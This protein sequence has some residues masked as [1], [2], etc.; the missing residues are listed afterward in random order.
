[1]R[2]FVL[3]TGSRLF[4]PPVPGRR[5]MPFNVDQF[6][7]ARAL[8]A[9]LKSLAGRRATVARNTV[10]VAGGGFTGIETVAEMP[11]RLRAILGDDANIRSSAEQASHIWPRSPGRTPGQ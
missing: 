7:H 1:M 10:V 2:K 5:T 8:D 4:Q 3:A 11:E 9:H 6:E